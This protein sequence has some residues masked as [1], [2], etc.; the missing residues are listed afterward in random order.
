MAIGKKA[1]EAITPDDSIRSSADNIRGVTGRSTVRKRLAQSPTGK[2]ADKALPVSVARQLAFGTDA[3]RAQLRAM[4]QELSPQAQNN[5]FRSIS[6]ATRDPQSPRDAI[7]LTPEGQMLLDVIFKGSEPPPEVLK[8]IARVGDP[9]DGT[10]LDTIPAGEDASPKSKPDAPTVEGR[11]LKDISDT[12]A[13]RSTERLVENK[14]GSFRV[15]H[16]DVHL[17]SQTNAAI[18]KAEGGET[19]SPVGDFA[20]RRAAAIP[21]DDFTRLLMRTAEVR[22]PHSGLSEGDVTDGGVPG[23]VFAPQ[24]SGQ[25]RVQ[26][27]SITTV[28][29]ADYA[30]LMRLAQM[31]GVSNPNTF[32]SPEEFAR[33]LVGGADQEG[34]NVTPITGSARAQATARV[35]DLA[36]DP[37]L[38]PAG[39]AER[40]V[41]TYQP[42]DVAATKAAERAL[43]QEQAIAALARKAE[44]IFG[45]MG[46]GDNYKGTAKG[47]SGTDAPST[48]GPSIAGTTQDPAQVPA[49]AGAANQPGELHS[50]PQTFGKPGKPVSSPGTDIDPELTAGDLDYDAAQTQSLDLNADPIPGGEKDSILKDRVTDPRPTPVR[51]EPDKSYQ[52]PEAQFAQYNRENVQLSDSDARTRADAYERLKGF[53]PL[54]QGRSSEV[55]QQIRQIIDG[56]ADRPLTADESAQLAVLQNELRLT[57][58]L[59][60]MSGVRSFE[61]PDAGDIPARAMIPADNPAD[62]QAGRIAAA[63]RE[64]DPDQTEYWDDVNQR[65]TSEDPYGLDGNP[66]VNG[67]G[68]G[69]PPDRPR[70]E[71]TPA[72]NPADP[73]ATPGPVVAPGKMSRIAKI[74]LGLGG[75]AGGYQV[76]REM[77]KTPEPDFDYYGGKREESPEEMGFLPDAMENTYGGGLRPILTGSEDRI[78]ALQG[79]MGRM[80]L[81]SNTQLPGNWTR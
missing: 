44:E 54:S 73:P 72:G 23:S 57:H 9:A 20:A 52:D 11:K 50:T 51:G 6:L 60:E 35:A 40:E 47:V 3:D 5:L 42:G 75:V 74:A 61:E 81:N 19:P 33:A 64:F 31:R 76:I 49:L 17:D 77:G 79:T 22:N 13:F 45:H 48:E 24:G 26:G 7:S 53:M 2:E 14:D 80:K 18:K 63:N 37:S 38:I 8:Q 41:R 55:R 1:I 29:P 36:D 32:A 62:L 67:G 69:S 58:R 21:K 68:A 59:D 30:A 4:V 27:R 46:W 43:V 70:L 65:W 39:V 12:P 10:P 71:A 78:R 28:N 34:F 66:R 15:D 25:K 56:A 16:T